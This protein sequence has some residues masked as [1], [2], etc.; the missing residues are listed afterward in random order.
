MKA[1]I[2]LICCAAIFLNY[3]ASSPKKEVKGPSGQAK[4]VSPK[5][6]P[7]S[8]PGPHIAKIPIDPND[9]MSKDPYE[10]RK[11]PKQA[12]KTIVTRLEKKLFYPDAEVN[13]VENTKASDK[14]ML[15]N[16]PVMGDAQERYMI[17]NDK[18]KIFYKRLEIMVGAISKA[19]KM[20][21]TDTE[22]KLHAIKKKIM[23]DPGLFTLGYTYC[24][25]A[26]C[27]SP[28]DIKMMKITERVIIVLASMAVKIFEDRSDLLAGE[29]VQNRLKM[30]NLPYETL[31]KLADRLISKSI[32][33]GI[34][35][36]SDTGEKTLYLSIMPFLN[37]KED[38]CSYAIAK[39]GL[40][41]RS[42]NKMALK[43]GQ[44]LLKQLK[45]YYIKLT[46]PQ[47]PPADK[48]TL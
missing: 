31:K 36:R 38:L 10:L 33:K 13:Y 29:C 44:R 41:S 14:K 1:N 20:T 43:K 39:Q 42:K 34:Y 32:K 45:P 22:I 21:L 17:P 3:C 9:K 12:V 40:F 47:D 16:E 23:E 26:V 46:P 2:F 30:I 48:K 19:G 18:K 37:M 8:P 15:P 25:N 6:V 7:K 24:D 11:K 4:K 5:K 28:K 27:D 35:L